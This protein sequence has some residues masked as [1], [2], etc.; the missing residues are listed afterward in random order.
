MSCHTVKQE[1]KGY[2]TSQW[3]YDQIQNKYDTAND[4]T[5]TG[6]RHNCKIHTQ[7]T[8]NKSGT[9]KKEQ[10]QRLQTKTSTTNKARIQK[11]FANKCAE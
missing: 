6:L 2:A 1:Q 5:C 7:G 11:D 10:Q 8:F 9:Q 4:H 3:Y